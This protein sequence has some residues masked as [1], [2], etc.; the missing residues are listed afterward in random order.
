[1][2]VVNT[3]RINS[4]TES[5]ITA[6]KRGVHVLV[7]QCFGIAYGDAFLIVHAVRIAGRHRPV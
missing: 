4:I 5:V 7:I 6:R 2:K 3:I 1:M